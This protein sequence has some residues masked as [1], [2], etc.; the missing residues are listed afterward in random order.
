MWKSKVAEVMA[1]V[2]FLFCIVL[3]YLDNNA[4]SKFSRKCVSFCFYFVGY[5]VI[6]VYLF[7]FIY[8]YLA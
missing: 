8:I 3:F 4:I 1:G 6:I 7:L 2:D 5:F